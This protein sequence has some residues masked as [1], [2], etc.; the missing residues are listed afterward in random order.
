MAKNRSTI[1]DEFNRPG[2]WVELK[3]AGKVPVDLTGWGL[4]DDPDRPGRWRFP[5]GLVIAP[6]G[7]LLI[8]CDDDETLGPLHANFKLSSKGEQLLLS[9]PAA[10]ADVVIDQITFGKQKRDR[11]LGRIPD[12]TGPF[13][14]LADP[15]PLAPNFLR[16]R[17]YR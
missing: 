8:W 15:S 14:S 7:Y 3:N 6:G 16:D 4:S 2:D 9:G 11:S 5:D 10:A 17:S 12:G 13:Q 1:Y